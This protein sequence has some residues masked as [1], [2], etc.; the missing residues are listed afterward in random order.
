MC[1]NVR[2]QHSLVVSVEKKKKKRHKRHGSDHG[3][4]V[5]GYACGTVRLSRNTLYSVYWKIRSFFI[6]VPLLLLLL[7]TRSYIY[8]YIQLLAS[9]PRVKHTCHIYH[10]NRNVQT[11]GER[12]AGGPPTRVCRNRIIVIFFFFFLSL[13]VYHAAHQPRRKIYTGGRGSGRP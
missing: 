10:E 6:A 13:S 8:I 12:A 7:F 9:Y 4:L 2:P 11:A 3:R 1:L 5:Y